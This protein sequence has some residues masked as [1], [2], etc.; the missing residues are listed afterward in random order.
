VPGEHRVLC[1][2]S[3]D[4]FRWEGANFGRDSRPTVTSAVPGCGPVGSEGSGAVG[5]YAGRR[6]GRMTWGV[7]GRRGHAIGA[8]GSLHCGG[9]SEVTLQGATL[10]TCLDIGGHTG[11]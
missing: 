3:V 9:R 10:G 11:V 5:Y 7:V 6:G 4:M 2:G 8:G 1:R